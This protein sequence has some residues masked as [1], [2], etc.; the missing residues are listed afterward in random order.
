MRGNTLRY[1]NRSVFAQL[2]QNLALA[3]EVTMLR[4]LHPC[5][6]SASTFYECSLV[7]LLQMQ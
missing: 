4:F 1:I 6:N 5:A 2:G 7:C 3:I